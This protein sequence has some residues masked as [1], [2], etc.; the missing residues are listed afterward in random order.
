MRVGGCWKTN[1]HQGC[2]QKFLGRGGGN[3]GQEREKEKG[4]GGRE[5]VK[6]GGKE[7]GRN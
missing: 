1:E 6:G 5:K 2:I 3:F 4:K 7:G